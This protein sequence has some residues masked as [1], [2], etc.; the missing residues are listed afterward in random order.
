MPVQTPDAALSQTMQANLPQLLR[1]LEESGFKAEF[2]PQPTVHVAATSAPARTASTDN[3]QTG[4]FDQGNS[5]QD[6]PAHGQG[7][8]KRQPAHEWRQWLQHGRKQN[9]EGN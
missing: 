7:R 3:R 1:G 4:S 2:Q 9:K 5:Q 6:G 8:E